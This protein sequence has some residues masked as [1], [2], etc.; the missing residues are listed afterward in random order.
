[1]SLNPDES[2]GEIARHRESVKKLESETNRVQSPLFK[3]KI[4]DTKPATSFPVLNGIYFRF[5]RVVFN[6]TKKK[7]FGLLRSMYVNERFAE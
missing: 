3:D 7:M 6:R 1:M 2:N 4:Y 5:R